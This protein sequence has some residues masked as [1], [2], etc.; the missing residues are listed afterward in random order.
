[1]KCKLVYSFK[2]PAV[3]HPRLGRPQVGLPILHRRRL[4]LL[5]RGRAVGRGARGGTRR[6]SSTSF[7]IAFFPLPPKEFEILVV[8]PLYS[9]R[10]A[11][12]FSP[13]SLFPG[14]LG[15]VAPA[16]GISKKMSKQFVSN[17]YFI[18]RLI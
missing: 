17:S 15:V 8:S 7:I 12:Y 4:L 14:V 13:V 18:Y 9:P 11:I 1:M 10:L 6:R 16:Q 3:E 2:L 5:T